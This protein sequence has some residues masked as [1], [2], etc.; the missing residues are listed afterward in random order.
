MKGKNEGR[1]RIFTANLDGS[2][3]LQ[4]TFGTGSPS[5]NGPSWSGPLPGRIAFVREAPRNI[6]IMNA[7][8][9]NQFQ[10]SADD[11]PWF[12]AP[13]RVAL[14]P[15]G[16]RIVFDCQPTAHI[17]DICIINS[18]GSG[19]AQLTASAGRN[20]GPRWTRDGRIFFTSDRTG[21]NEVFI[22]NADGSGLTNLTNSPT[23]ESTTSPN[24]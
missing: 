3:P 13:P 6:W 1:Y 18:D 8:G 7:D 22:M 9:T 24:L 17:P 4:L 15:D 11:D 19:R 21:N 14:S 20:H 12:H 10:V 5:E 23:R 16:L 2:N